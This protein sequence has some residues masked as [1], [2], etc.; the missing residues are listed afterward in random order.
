MILHITKPYLWFPVEKDAPEVKLNFYLNHEKIQEIDIHLGGSEKDFY[1]CMDV[2]RYMEQDI[3]IQS[4]VDEDMLYGIFCCESKVQNIYP[5]RPHLHFS[6]EIGWNND[7]NGLV[8][9]NGLYHLYYQWNPYGVTWGNMHWGHAVSK[10]LFAWEHRPMAIA[11]DE[12]GTIYSGCAWPDQENITGHGSRALLF[13]YTAAGGMNRWSADKGHLFTQRLRVSTDGGETMQLSDNFLLGHITG[14]NRDPKIF[15]HKES[16]AY[17]M[18]L[19]LEGYTFAIYRSAD[20][21]SWEETCRLSIKGMQECPDLFE[22]PVERTPEKGK[23]AAEV[24]PE[25]TPEKKWVFWAADGYYVVGSFDGYRFIQETPCQPAYCTKLPYAAQSYAGVNHRVIS[26]AWLRMDNCRGNYRGLMSIPAEL[27]LVK[28]NNTYN[29]K[30]QP[31]RELQP[32]CCP[33]RNLGSGKRNTHLSLTGAPV[34][35]TLSWKPQNTGTTKLMLGNYEITIDFV[36]ETIIFY[37]LKKHADTARIPFCCNEHLTLRFIIDQEVVEF[38][39]NDGIIY[40]A[41]EVEENILRKKLSVESTAEIDSMKC[42]EIYP[43]FRSA[44]Y[45]N[46]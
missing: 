21:L 6:P 5:F 2:N 35:V 11:P 30:F 24:H 32:Y 7:P 1:T 19:Y 25:E 44:D 26:I 22:L 9:A 4:D 14:E 38:W 28:Q 18:L 36:R 20:L 27:S 23:E 16:S 39:G 33:A 10:D 45:G 13:Y 46:N 31:V 29:I 40:G 15:Y 43:A 17:I 3:E 12:Y 42:C 8:F 37:D 34:D 41:V